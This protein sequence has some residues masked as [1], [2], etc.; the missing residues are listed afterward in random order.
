MS[1]F[2][3]LL[4]CVCVRRAIAA[5]DGTASLKA[6]EQLGNLQVRQAWAAAK[7]T[8]PPPPPATSTKRKRVARGRATRG[9][10]QQARAQALKTAS[11]AIDQGFARLQRVAAIEPSVERLSLC[12]SAWKRQAMVAKLA[13]DQGAER[14]ALEKMRDWYAR[15]EDLA[16]K[17]NDPGLFYPA[18]NR[19][20][21]EIAGAA[22]RRVALDAA[23]LDPVRQNLADRNRDNPDF[24]SVV[25]L[26]DLRMYEA[27][28]RREL[29]K[30]LPAIERD[31][32]DLY[33][34]CDADWLWKSVSDQADFVLSIYAAATAD[35]ELKAA[36]SLR[37]SL[38]KKA[39]V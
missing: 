13:G 7:R 24:W 27:L 20:A 14:A 29:A 16:R 36:Q 23:D 39:R 1:R 19:I 9:A 18:L 28:A 15:A 10:G 37:E 33:R 22:G 8:P 35:S 3:R 2:D 11:A 30:A 34:R 12:G 26:T 5:N 21:A 17:T 4:D 38:A 6:V 32:D 31:Y 25:A